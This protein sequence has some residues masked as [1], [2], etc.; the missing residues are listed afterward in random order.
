MLY[1]GPLPGGGASTPLPDGGVVEFPAGPTSMCPRTQVVE[2]QL[3]NY[4]ALA[5]A[6]PMLPLG[7]STPTDRALETLTARFGSAQA[8]DGPVSVVLA[9]DGAPNDFCSNNSQL[10]PPDVRPAVISAVSQLLKNGVTTYAL[11]L[12][13]GDQ[14]LT[15]HLSQVAAAGGTGKSVFTP[16]DTPALSSAL[17]EIVGKQDGCSVRLASRISLARA[18]E[19]TVTLEGTALKCGD[20]NGFSLHDETTLQLSGQACERYRAAN[21]PKL[22]IDYPCSALPAP[23]R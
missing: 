11:S 10:P 17:R 1:D 6:F 13:A 9:T 3:N 16:S 19:G 22:D 15:E 4:S 7:G 12:A 5:A 21:A 18:C 8:S 23:Q 14:M 2:P 20:A